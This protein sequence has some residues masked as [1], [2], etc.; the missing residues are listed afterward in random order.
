LSAQQIHAALCPVGLQC[1][2]D[3]GDPVPGSR[4]V[5]SGQVP[6]SQAGA[7][8]VRLWLLF[9]P[10]PPFGL[11]APIFRSSG[12]GRER[13][14]GHCRPQLS[15]CLAG[16]SRKHLLFNGARQF[17][18]QPGHAVDDRQCLWHVDL[19]GGQCGPRGWQFLE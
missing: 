16:G 17:A 13:G 9:H 8:A 1:P 3:S 7:D 10:R 2:G 19:P 14:A 6:P 18:A 12:V 15:G 11:G 5:G 4:S